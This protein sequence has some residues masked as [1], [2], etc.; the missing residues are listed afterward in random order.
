MGAQL[1]KMKKSY[2]VPAVEKAVLILEYITHSEGGRSLRDIHTDL[3]IAKTTVFSTLMTLTECG[4]VR[5]SSDGLYLPTLKL[6]MLGAKARSFAY[7]SNFVRPRLEVLRDKTGF[8]VFFCAYDKGELF[9]L[10]KIDGFSGVIFQTNVEQ[11][12]HINTSGSGKAMAAFIN[13]TELQAVLD[14]GLKKLTE[15][16]ICEEEAFLQHLEEIRKQGYAFDDNEGEMG[17]RCIGAPVFM[18]N[19]IVYGA[20]SV[21]TLSEKLLLSDVSKYATMVQEVAEDISRSLGYAP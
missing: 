20:V 2:N 15:N 11:R 21:S 13:P 14:K 10:E 18:Y 5:K 16:S 8:T 4:F 7:D 12:K 3:N 17:V 9:V 1:F 19:G 6:T